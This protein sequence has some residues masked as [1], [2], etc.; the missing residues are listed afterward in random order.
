MC[1][2]MC[3]CVCVCVNV[4]S[5]DWLVGKLGLVDWLL[6]VLVTGWCFYFLLMSL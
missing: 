3:V 4:C 2:C 6:S 5:N 1:V